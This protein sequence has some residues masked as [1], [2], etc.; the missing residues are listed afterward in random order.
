MARAF[1]DKC[2][3]WQVPYTVIALYGKRLI[4]H[5]NA[6]IMAFATSRMQLLRETSNAAPVGN[7]KCGSSGKLR[8]ENPETSKNPEIFS[9]ENIPERGPGTSA[10]E[11]W[12]G[13]RPQ[14][15]KAV[16]SQ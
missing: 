6:I 3:L 11:D 12:G 4:W 8:I 5:H 2:L 1:Y 14:E 16:K 15:H 9:L 10:S 7:R 13:A